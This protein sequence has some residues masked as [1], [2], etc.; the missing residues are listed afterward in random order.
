MRIAGGQADVDPF[1]HQILSRDG[2]NRLKAPKLHRRPV[3][4]LRSTVPALTRSATPAFKHTINV[5]T[6]CVSCI[7][8]AK[9]L[10]KKAI[11]FRMPVADGCH[12][13][14]S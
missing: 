1:F 8:A 4:H 13:R 3:S 7:H 2:C 9:S 11:V 10:H 6:N 5:V 12:Y 14:R